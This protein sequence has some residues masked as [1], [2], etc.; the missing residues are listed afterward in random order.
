MLARHN[1]RPLLKN[2][3]SVASEPIVIVWQP[4]RVAQRLDGF[5]AWVAE[6]VPPAESPLPEGETDDPRVRAAARLIIRLLSP[7]IFA[8]PYIRLWLSL[9][10]QRLWAEH[11]LCPPMVAN[12]GSTIGLTVALR[13]DYRTGYAAARHALAVGEAHGYE[14]ETS[15]ARYVFASTAQPWFEPLEDC[16]AQVQLAR[17]GLIRGG[18]LRIASLAYSETMVGLLDCAATLDEYA[19][20]V[21]ARLAFAARTGYGQFTGAF[22]A[23]RQLA[24]ALRGETNAVGGFTDGS[25]DEAGHPASLGPNLLAAVG[26]HV[27]RALAAAPTIAPACSSNWTRAAT[28]WRCARRTHLTISSTCS[29]WSRRSAPGPSTTS[30]RPSSRLTRRIAPSRMVGGH[31]TPR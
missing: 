25:F 11:G 27:Q 17:E 23:H 6:L 13:Q 29:S 28:G 31:G 2:F 7:G 26:L 10:S 16:V 9:A 15:I 18:D 12:L 19:I 24:R 20:E 3:K 4:N 22:L 21:A 14:P 1:G 30:G 8:D 5:Y